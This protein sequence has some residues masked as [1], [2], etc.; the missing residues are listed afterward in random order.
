MISV[1]NLRRLLRAARFFLYIVISALYSSRSSLYIS[2]SSRFRLTTDLTAWLTSVGFRFKGLTSVEDSKA[3]SVLIYDRILLSLALLWTRNSHSSQSREES[4]IMI[5][6]RI[7][8]TA[9]NAIMSIERC[10]WG[11]LSRKSGHESENECYFCRKQ[12]RAHNCQ[13]N[14]WNSSF[15]LCRIELSTIKVIELTV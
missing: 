13:T 2:L 5:V 11:K 9:M 15:C 14:G 10:K 4:R 7:E 1:M 12:L 3:K 6:L 8:G